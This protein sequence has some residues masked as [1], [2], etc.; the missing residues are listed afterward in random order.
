MTENTQAQPVNLTSL[1]PYYVYELI[2]PRD[3]NVFYVGKGK[4]NRLE[5]HQAGEGSS[6]ETMIHSIEQAG[7]EVN[8]I[9]IGRYDTESE[10]FAVEITL[11]KW[12]H[13][14]DNL[15]NIDPGRY[16]ALVR[17]QSE[18][19]LGDYS[20][21]VG[22]DRERVLNISTGEYTEDQVRQIVENNIFGKL[23]TISIYLASELNKSISVSE[24]NI[25]RAQDPHIKI[26]GFSDHIS[27]I[28]KLRL[29]GNDCT[30]AFLPMGQTK[31]Q[32]DNFTISMKHYFGN[33][34][35]LKQGNVFGSSYLLIKNEDGR[36]DK[37]AYSDLDRIKI[38]LERAIAQVDFPRS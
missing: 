32:D 6:K 28:L 36:P 31:V 2:D 14:Y 15:T 1:K 19:L 23:E 20:H 9:I 4:G 27:I 38:K 34:V 7:Q 33:D 22:I 37:T 24:P 25:L 29:T 30:L 17:A 11:I 12:V 35:P 26:S 13:G 3:N 21:I 5:A 10:A 18:K 8:R 16:H